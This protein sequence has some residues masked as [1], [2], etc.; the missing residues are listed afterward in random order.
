MLFNQIV[1]LRTKIVF[2]HIDFF[3]LGQTEPQYDGK[4]ISIDLSKNAN[5]G[6]TYVHECLH[7]IF[8]EFSETEVLR[9]EREVWKS[10]TPKQ[11]FFIYKRVFNRRYRHHLE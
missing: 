8:P 9:T 3:T 10:L 7:Y 2:R 11:K 1:N 4:T 5:V 6:R